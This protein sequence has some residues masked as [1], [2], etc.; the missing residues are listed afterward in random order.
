VS[1]PEPG[2]PLRRIV[3]VPLVLFAVVSAAVFTLAKLHLAKPDAPASASSVQ[4]GDLYRGETIFVSE[5]SGC[6]GMRGE[7]GSGP[8]LAGAA[9]SIAEAKAQIDNGGG[10]MPAR[11][12]TGQDEEDVLAY[13]AA[14][15]QP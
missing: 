2:W 11:L 4:L 14:L 15:L 6:H 1:S 10:A 3:V 9:I 7:G 13:L 12:V 8:R 5:C